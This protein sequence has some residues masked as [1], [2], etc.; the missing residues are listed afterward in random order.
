MRKSIWMAKVKEKFKTLSQKM[1]RELRCHAQ[2][3]SDTKYCQRCKIIWNLIKGNSPT[4]IKN[5]LECSTS[6]IMRIA[7]RFVDE[8]MMG[9]VD[10]REDNGEPKITEDHEEFLLIAAA[11]SP[12]DYGYDRP[13]WTLELFIHVL[14]KQTGSKVSTT[15]MSRTLARLAIRCKQPKP[16]VLCPWK[17]A[18]RTRKLNEIRRLLEE[19][20]ED[21]VILYVDEVDIHLNPKIGPDWMPC[22]MQKMV[23]TPGKNKKHYLAGALNARTGQVTYVERDRKNSDLFID[24]LWTLVL[25]DYPHA[26]RIHLILD[27]YRIHSSKRTQIALDALSEKVELHFLPP[28]CPDHNKIERVWKDLHANV[29]RNHTCPSMKELMREVRKY[30][31]TR[32]QRKEQETKIA[33]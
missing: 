14:A 18:K 19:T 22:G 1:K 17:K 5:H 11:G 12:R 25:D 20:P 6:S 10:R 3:H 32:N 8:G 31:K 2:F 27:N 7:A 29:T 21:E 16:F 26:K 30:I 23:L 24:Q 13:T 4:S 15:T 33:A 9:L 28:Y